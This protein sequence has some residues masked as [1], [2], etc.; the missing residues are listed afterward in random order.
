M[1]NIIADLLAEKGPCL[2]TDLTAALVKSGLSPDAARKQV[3]RMGS[4]I[5][6]LPHLIFPHRARF[7]YLQNDCGSRRYWRALKKAIVTKSAAY[8]PALAALTQRGGIMPKVHF[9]IACGSPI[10]QKKQLS[11]DVIYDRF[12]WAGIT[13]EIEV[14]GVGT[15]VIASDVDEGLTQLDIAQLKARLVT[16]DILLLA[17]RDWIRKLGLASYEKIMIRDTV[18]SLPRVGTF[19]WDLTGPS[20]LA[21]MVDWAGNEK[22]KPG[23]IA[24]DVLLSTVDE[25][26]I[27]P[28]IKKC[29]TLRN[30]KKVG[31]CLQIFVAERYTEKAF[32]QAKQAGL[33]P[34]TPESLFGREVAQ[35]LTRLTEV[36]T[37]AATSAITHDVFEELFQ[38][39]GRIE[40]AA[41]NLRGALFELIAAELARELEG[42]HVTINK[43]IK[44]DETD[45]K[46]EIDVLVVNDHRRVLF[47]EC[48]G[49]LPTV[50]VD[51]EL[52]KLWLTDRVPLIRKY[53]LQHQDWKRLEHRFEF[54]TTGM[55][56]PVAVNMLHYAT[57]T[58]KKYEIGYKSAEAI[59]EYVTP[60]KKSPLVKTLEQHFFNHPLVS[61]EKAAAA[62][63]GRAA[64]ARRQTAEL[65]LLP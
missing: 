5:N 9:S 54:W 7:V 29:T 3:S 62:K 20:Y 45:K 65:G 36:L 57:T 25:Y 18:E 43:I 14:P 23:F 61:L 27:V 21:P 2:T 40:G 24:C 11:A 58:T 30:L 26:G 4:P 31:R 48:K 13:R 10:R 32:S 28:F 38:S 51:D 60:I 12:V 63:E 35:G 6:R 16:E 17:V 8:G 15:C 53:A 22:P 1:R 64:R 46:A 47:I 52:V 41:G 39:L 34:A 42:G 55:L 19:A 56:S 49:N 50:Q 33:V 59:K 44:D 37:Q